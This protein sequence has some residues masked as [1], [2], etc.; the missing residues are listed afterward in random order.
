M[1]IIDRYI[2]KQLS[3]MLCFIT[4]SLVG[5]VWLTQS[6]R[7]IDFVIA[8]GLPL[9]T[10]IKLI[11]LLLPNLLGT[12]L[13]VGFLI[14]LLFVF[15]RFYTDS[16]L[17]IFKSIG[18]TNR[19]LLRAPTILGVIL[20]LSL[21][22][23]NLYLHP[24]STQKF[25]DYKNEIR[26]H[27]SSYLIQP[28]EFTSFKEMTFYVK[29]R[30]ARGEMSGLFVHDNK[31]PNKP[32]TLVAEKGLVLETPKGLRLVLFN[33]SRQETEKDTGKPSILNF[34]QYSLELIH[35]AFS[36]EDRERKP[37]E[38][39]LDDLLNPTEELPERLKQKRYVEAHNRLMSPLIVFPFM[40]I[41]LSVFLVGQYERKGRLRKIIYAVTGC[42]GFQVT[43][44]YLLNLLKPD[45]TNI[46]LPYG[47]ILSV[48]LGLFIYINLKEMWRQDS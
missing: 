13:P 23:I 43:L 35:G 17:I 47:M 26:N 10:F 30:N 4:F 11:S 34:E 15:N 9:M 28:S 32:V 48:C 5:A 25:K 36:S 21:Y 3:L 29:S 6:L 40:L 38:L 16:E 31:D 22:G 41:A 7:Y 39:S 8:K 24:Y 2:L 14:A 1:N 12:V 37:A 20:C 27:V 19:H 44:L 42:V 33:G 45:A 46:W 18:M